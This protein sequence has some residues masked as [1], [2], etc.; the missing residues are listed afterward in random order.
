[1]IRAGARRIIQD[2]VASPTV[3]RLAPVPFAWFELAEHATRLAR[4]TQSG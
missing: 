1:L 4:I 2:I 3:G